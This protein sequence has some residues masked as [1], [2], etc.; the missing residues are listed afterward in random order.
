M[1]GDSFP[2]YEPAG[3]SSRGDRLELAGDCP[4]VQGRTIMEMEGRSSDWGK[5]R[6]SY[7][8]PEQA[9][10]DSLR[11]LEALEDSGGRPG[12]LEILLPPRAQ[13]LF[14]PEEV[15]LRSDPG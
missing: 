3:R 5:I 13:I 2:S 14:R 10:E 4:K 8:L 1:R 12:H 7:P 11:Q 9:A 6:N 15:E